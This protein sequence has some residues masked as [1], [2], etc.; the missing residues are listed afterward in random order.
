M[1]NKT[2]VVISAILT[3]ILLVIIAIVSVFTQMIA[4]NGVSESQGMTAM[5]ISLVCQGVGV[6]FAGLFA[7]WIS[8]FVIIRF[9]WNKI[10]AVIVAVVAGV[11]IGGIISLISTIFSI[12][13][14]GIR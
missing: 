12:P 6:I 11:L 14:V 3:I 4:L 10:L 2:A 8:N 9:N 1:L 5:G 7:G 13:L